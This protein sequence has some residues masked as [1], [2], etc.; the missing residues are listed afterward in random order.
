MLKCCSYCK[1]EFSP[2]VS[3][4][5]YCSK[6]CADKY[7]VSIRRYG[8]LHFNVLERDNHTCQKCRSVDD[9]VVHHVDHDVDHNEMSNLITWCRP[10]HTSYH[11]QLELNNMYKHITKERILKAIEVTSNLEEAST[12]LGITRKTLIKKRR[13]YG[14]PELSVGRQGEENKLYKH[15]TV[16]EI[17]MA[18]ELEGNW[19][20]VAK[21]LNV[22]SSFLRKR[23]K[24]LG[25]EM[26]A[27]KTN[28]MNTQKG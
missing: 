9:L 15:L 12:L 13:E 18:F 10:C 7:T 16:N 2:T 26:D 17:N 25:M 1:K 24:N 20:K 3:H 5:R 28:K 23:R 27:K 8:G 22:S 19:S 6:V 21:R 4:Q 14:L 11:Q